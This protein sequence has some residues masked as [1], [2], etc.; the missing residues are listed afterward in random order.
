MGGTTPSSRLVALRIIQS[1]CRVSLTPR[2]DLVSSDKPWD[3]YA[4]QR[5]A[6]P[7]RRTPRSEGGQHMIMR[8][9]WGKLYPNTWDE[10]ERAYKE[11]LAGKEAK[12]LRGRWL[13]RDVNDPDG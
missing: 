3:G 2:F 9:T 11:T 6:V 12:G 5:R 7:L 4:V 13:A 10:F 8:I 1:G